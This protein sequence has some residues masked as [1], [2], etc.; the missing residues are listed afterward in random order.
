[1]LP[2]GWPVWSGYTN[3]NK[4][5][6]LMCPTGMVHVLVPNLGIKREFGAG[7]HHVSPPI[8]KLPPQ[9]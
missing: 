5:L 1:M 4:E 8:P 9:L 7:A 3:R 6:A 2:E